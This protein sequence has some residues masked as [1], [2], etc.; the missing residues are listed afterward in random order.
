MRR[1]I[2]AGGLV[3]L[4]AP[5]LG[6][7][8]GQAAL[9]QKQPGQARLAFERGV[10]YLRKQPEPAQYQAQLKRFEEQLARANAMVLNNSAPSAEVSSELTEGLKNL[11]DD[12]WKKK[13][14]YD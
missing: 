7:G 11:G 8:L 1:S 12:D 10:Q 4:A 13:N 14:I 6:Q 2:E 5:L 9:Q 3:H